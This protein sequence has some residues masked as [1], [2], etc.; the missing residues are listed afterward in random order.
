MVSYDSQCYRHA[1]V[2]AAVG[3]QR[4][5]KPICTACMTQA[6][7]GHHCPKCVTGA[8]QVVNYSPRRKSGAASFPVTIGLIAV[9]VV[10][11]VLQ[12]SMALSKNN[13][14]RGR[15]PVECEGI[16]EGSLV[17]DGEFWRL[18]TS[19][20][21]HGSLMHIGFNMYILW[22][23]GQGLEQT[24]D[25]VR[26]LLVYFAALFGGSLAVVVFAHQQATL[27]A[28]GAVLGLGGALAVVLWS[29]GINLFNQSSLGIFLGLNLVLP[30]I[31]PRISFWGHLGGVVAGVLA[32]YVGIVLVEKGNL[33]LSQ[34]RLVLAGLVVALAIAGLFGAGLV[35]A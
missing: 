14:C 19:G 15:T 4:C 6:S 33:S 32:G 30:F 23:L 25:R 31:L 1:G 20:F 27:G 18:L 21:L 9:N 10:M 29:R 28:S 17:A 7:I 12:N 11:F 16:L 2:R 34:S 5:E 3:C 26:Y 24:I 35:A 22:S 8:P 13:E